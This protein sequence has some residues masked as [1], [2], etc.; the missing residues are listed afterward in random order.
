MNTPPS[1]GNESVIDIFVLSNSS[2]ISTRI[3]E[4]LENQGYYVTLFSDG[5]QLIDTLRSGKPNLL[6]CDATAPDPDGFEVCKQIK[7]DDYLWNIPVLILT[8][9]A[10]LVDLLKVLDSN[11]DNFIAHPYDLSYLLSLIEGMFNTPVE[12]QTPEQIKTQFKIQHD[13]KIFVVTA[14]RRKLLE[15][16]LSSFEIAITNEMNLSRARDEIKSLNS[17]IA[18]LESNASEQIRINSGTTESLR[19]QEQKT[20]ALADQLAVRE[21]ELGKRTEEISELSRALAEEKSGRDDAEKEIQRLL[22]KNDEREMAHHAAADAL[23]EQISS[24]SNDRDQLK[25]ALDTA[26]EALAQETSRCTDTETELRNIGE[27]RDLLDRDFRALTLESE[28]LK[29]SFTAE[30]NRAQAA[31]QETSA[32]LL[33][34]TEAEQELTKLIGEL[35]ETASRQAVELTRLKGELEAEGTRS[36]RLEET[37]RVLAGE[38]EQS[39]VSLRNQISAASEELGKVKATFE[40]T[41]ATLWERESFLKSLTE[42][43]ATVTD[44]RNQAEEK[45]KSVSQTLE[46]ARI[47]LADLEQ[48][49]A[50]QKEAFAGVTSQKD[51]AEALAA[52]LK[53][54][55]EEIRAELQ[56]WVEKHHELGEK[57]QAAISERD[58]YLAELRESHDE[59]SSDLHANRDELARVSQELETISSEKA[60][61]ESSLET[62]NLRIHDLESDL[63]A[64]S[65]ARKLA[66]KQVLS[67]AAELAQVRTALENEI[68]EHQEAGV[69]MH[70]VIRERDA[71]LKEIREAHEE[72]T[73]DLHANK[74]DLI[75]ARQELERVSSRNAALE[76]SLAATNARIHDLESELQSVSGARALTEQQVQSS[77]SEL[78][79]VQAALE[80]ETQEHQDAEETL[81][82]A[83][84]ERDAA[85]QELRESHDGIKSDLHA[86]REDLAQTKHELELILA[87]KTTL[88]GSLGATIARI[89]E[90]EAELHAVSTARAQAAQQVRSFS[91]ELEALK[92]ALEKETR[93]RLESEKSLQAASDAQSRTAQELQRL[94]HELKVAR[95]EVA[96]EQRLRQEAEGQVRA[97]GNERDALS[98]SLQQTDTE[99]KQAV[100]SRTENIRQLKADLEQIVSLQRTLEEQVT[101]LKRDKLQA[102]Q[103]VASLTAEIDQARV[104]LADEWEDHMTD[105]EKL[106]AAVEEKQHLVE[107]FQVKEAEPEKA[108]KRALIMKGPEL[109]AEIRPVP[110]ALAS[111]SPAPV[112]TPEIPDTSRITSVEDLFEDDSPVVKKSPVQPQVPVPVASP[113]DEPEILFDAPPQEADE[114]GSDGEEDVPEEEEES[115]DDG[116]DE[117]EPFPAEGAAAASPAIANTGFTRA[118]WLDLL[119]WSHHCDTFPHEQRMQIVRMGRLIQKGR[120]LTNKQEEQVLEIIAVAQRCGYRL[121]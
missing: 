92:A 83:V 115:E 20:T 82:A 54:T 64:A 99:R 56:N 105:S 66:E 46:E 57:M 88:E 106:A 22:R 18:R 26:K 37:L 50:L 81:C 85:L 45:L 58:A 91:G 120:V 1:D 75:Q 70:A 3:K 44:A 62:T 63:Q 87:H 95:S 16:L 9:A 110:H 68:R 77:A 93:E 23:Q 4:Q 114:T 116:G 6:I 11:A 55:L 108:K 69:S 78:A 113:A 41:S 103:K 86:N 73:T 21:E 32:V 67:S 121:P 24:L 51:A 27:Q 31:E 97:I 29:V 60:A 101:T 38:K 10:D 98:R 19:A 49:G 117:E 96:D 43:L 118:Q 76:S 36:S 12:R 90:L 33:A 79:K 107:S 72:V 17:S 35:N 100:E 7:A 65:A 15:F 84:R 102:E 109:P 59:V 61:L 111:V 94:A 39:E 80:K 30:K 14:D 53:G 112:H 104:A 48:K 40:M 89:R 74:D 71:A 13:E 25:A 28:Q 2:S 47:T 42:N 34:K 52:S 8:A 5:T 119:K